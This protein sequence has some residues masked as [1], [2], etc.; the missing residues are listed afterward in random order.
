MSIF[1][2]YS[3]LKKEHLDITTKYIEL[4]E[5]KNKTEEE[6]QKIKPL[7]TESI[8]IT[9][10]RIY[11]KRIMET[12]CPGNCTP[13][14]FENAILFEKPLKIE[15]HNPILGICY[16]PDYDI[17]TPTNKK[18]LLNGKHMG[19]EA[20]MSTS[21]AAGDEAEYQNWDKIGNTIIEILTEQFKIK[22]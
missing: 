16:N 1:N 11:G 9:F 17:N 22:E 13:E 2:R 20:I 7:I 15:H 21:Y 12:D 4:I 10:C 6:F 19:L 18:L 14:Y 3:K 5:Q 8:L